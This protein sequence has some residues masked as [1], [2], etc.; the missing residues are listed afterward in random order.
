MIKINKIINQESKIN[1]INNKIIRLSLKELIDSQVHTGS[2]IKTRN[3]NNL[4]NIYATRDY[5]DI[6]NLQKTLQACEPVLHL[7]IQIIANS[8]KLLVISQHPFTLKH[9]FPFTLFS[10]KWVHGTLSNYKIIR[11]SQK[12]ALSRIPNAVIILNTN[13]T[14]IIL[15]ETTYLEIPTITLNDTSHNPLKV[16]Y[17]IPANS[18]SELTI[19][20]FLKLFTQASY[21]GH[22]KLIWKF[23]SLSSKKLQSNDIQRIISYKQRQKLSYSII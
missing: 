19:N 9:S 20:L 1:N 22:A 11:Q 16:H 6:I 17:P 23:K 12:T 10:N 4:A 18:S 14:D 13:A 7:I 15:N 3:F 8:E 21:Y 5:F 2:H